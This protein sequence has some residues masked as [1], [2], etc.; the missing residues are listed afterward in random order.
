MDDDKYTSYES[1]SSTNTTS[2]PFRFYIY[3]LP[4]S[5]NY[6][7]V[8][9]YHKSHLKTCFNFSHYGMGSEIFKTGQEDGSFYVYDTHQFSLE[10]IIHEKLKKNVLRTRNPEKADIF[11][12]PAY[13][14]LLCTG[15]RHR[16]PETINKLKNL[17]TNSYYFSIGK[18]HFSTVSKIQKEMCSDVCPYLSQTFTNKVTF[19]SIEKQ[20]LSNSVK[21]IWPYSAMFKNSVLV[22]P[23]PSYGHFK[24]STNMDLSTVPYNDR[25]VYIL[26]AVSERRTNPQRSKLM[27][28]FEMRTKLGYS[29]FKIC[30][31]KSQTRMVL[32]YTNECNPDL[33]KLLIPWMQHSVFCLQPPGDSPSRKSFYDSVMSGCIPVIL[34]DGDRHNPYAFQDLIDY[35]TFTISIEMDRIAQHDHQISDILQDIPKSKIQKMQ[36]NIRQMARYMQYSLPSGKKER[37]NDALQLIFQ[38]LSIK[39]KLEYDKKIEF[40][41]QPI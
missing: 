14:G 27:D 23:Y 6:D 16:A 21:S 20:K 15:N 24:Q 33:A 34:T 30:H 2:L 36:D 41:H 37:E 18:P 1:T 22:A 39:F 25:D 12:I 40:L 10:V 11:Y 4:S 8:D 19:I 13:I 32:F 35:N 28:Q 17:L 9:S 29:R 26:L 38:Q 3:D 5:L 7:I 31:H